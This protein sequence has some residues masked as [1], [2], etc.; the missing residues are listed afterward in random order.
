L[1]CKY[2]GI[3][4]K[5]SGFYSPK[6]KTYI[7]EDIS[8]TDLSAEAQ[9]KNPTTLKL[10][11]AKAERV[12]FEPT[13]QYDPYDDLANRSFRPL[14]HLSINF[15]YSPG[16]LFNFDLKNPSFRPPSAESFRIVFFERATKIE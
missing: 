9:T 10:R 12:G 6:R 13:V 2:T 16:V 4:F 5:N 11:W 7:E 3:Q 1:G 14:R 8:K 15:S